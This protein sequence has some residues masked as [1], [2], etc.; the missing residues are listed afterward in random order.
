MERLCYYILY[1]I[2]KIKI[3]T[4]IPYTLFPIP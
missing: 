1:L 3:Q 4:T 2:P